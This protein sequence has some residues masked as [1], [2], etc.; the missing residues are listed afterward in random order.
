MVSTSPSRR[1]KLTMDQF[2]EFVRRAEPK[3]IAK[4]SLDQLPDHIPESLVDEAPYE[5]R[6]QIETL[7]FEANAYQINLAIELEAQFGPEINNALA[8]SKQK[9]DSRSHLLF[10]RKV[11]SLV[12]M[13][14]QSKKN[15]GILKSDPFNDLLAEVQRLIEDLRQESGALAHAR[16]FIEQRLLNAGP[17]FL[18][19]FKD[20][21]KVLTKRFADI[22]RSM[23]LYF[24]VS[25]MLAANEMNYVRDRIVDLERKGGAIKIRLEEER[26]QLKRLQ[27]NAITRRTKKHLI[28]E[29]QTN[30]TEHL[31]ELKQYEVMVSETDLLSWLDTVVEAS[32]SG[33]VRK[34]A[35]SVIRTARLGLFGLLQKYCMLQEESARQVARN[36]FSQID[37]KKSIQYMIKSEQFILDYFSKKKSS[38][39]AWLGGAAQTR[40]DSLNVLEKQLMVEMRK[41]MKKVGK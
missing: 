22:E 24:Y 25:V 18:T 21:I 32:L 15:P 3:H 30:I 1:R 23:N 37:P 39:T 41:N 38:I 26:N 2:R 6:H 13:Y 16:H 36:P 27:G 31:E 8:L 29:L 4:I 34:Q 17:K 40:I 33:Y 9:G 35:G 10:K 14:N 20:A 19:I 12:T 5:T 11:S 7:I 28:N